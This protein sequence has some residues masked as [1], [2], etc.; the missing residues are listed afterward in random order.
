MFLSDLEN[1]IFDNGKRLIP[2]VTHDITEVIRQRS[3]YA[4]CKKLILKDIELSKIAA[5]KILDLGCGVGHGSKLL[6]KI[7][8]ARVTGIDTSK[9]AIEYAEKFY[10]AENNSYF[11]E[12][13]LDLSTEFLDKFDY[14][15][16]EISRTLKEYSVCSE[17][18]NGRLILKFSGS[19]IDIKGKFVEFEA[20]RE[21]INTLGLAEYFYEDSD[22]QIYNG[23]PSPSEKKVDTLIV[24][25]SSLDFL[26]VQELNISFPVVAW[27]IATAQQWEMPGRRAWFDDEKSLLSAAH[28]YIRPGKV[29][30]EIGAGIHN[31]E[32]APAPFQILSDPYHE[33]ISVLEEKFHNSKNATYVTVQNTGQELLSHL[34]EKCV[35]TTLMIDVI[36]HIEKTIG[37]QLLED[38]E[39]VTRKQIVIFTPLGYLPQEHGTEI[40]AWGHHGAKW[41]K[42][43]SGWLPEDF[44]ESWSVLVCEKFR[45]REIDGEQKESGAIFAIK[46][47][48]PV[49]PASDHI[50]GGLIDGMAQFSERFLALEDRIEREICH[51]NTK[52]EAIHVSWYHRFWLKFYKAVSPIVNIIKKFFNVG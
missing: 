36:E 49:K 52:I 23:F 27:N 31:N 5:P 39:R 51:L 15:V 33:Y 28:D 26:C 4:F 32:Y 42:H 17:Q 37:K 35:D 7:P 40:D 3:F 46:N 12:D 11:I 18:I 50:I 19:K 1:K 8:F 24:V 16:S 43:V 30:L 21:K 48:L 9:D 14:I 44:D 22:G 29:S 6:S 10:A 41:Q 38:C 25:V 34:P 13:S 2:G 20:I 47:I 45:T